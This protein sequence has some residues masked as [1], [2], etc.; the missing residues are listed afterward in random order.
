VATFD[1]RGRILVFGTVEHQTLL[2]RLLANG[3]PDPSSLRSASVCQQ[4][5]RAYLG[6]PGG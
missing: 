4:P 5:G 1:R 6:G 3:E 2:I